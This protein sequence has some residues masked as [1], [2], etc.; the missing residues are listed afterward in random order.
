MPYCNDCDRF[1][2]PNT[3]NGAGEC[4]DGHVV[5]EPVPPPKVP[6]HFK[7]MVT[8]LVIYLAWRFIQLAQALL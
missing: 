5:A 2:N 4:P 3:L 7:V 6:W 1:Y 8:L